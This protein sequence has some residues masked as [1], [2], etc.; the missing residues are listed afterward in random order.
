MYFFQEEDIVPIDSDFLRGIS[1]IVPEEIPI[2]S[3]ER[4]D[5]SEVSFHS[6]EV[7]FHSSEEFFIASVENDKYPS[8]DLHIIL[9]NRIIMY[10][11]MQRLEQESRFVR[12]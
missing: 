9:A 11:Q 7:S 1:Q 3:E 5:S 12:R 4:K 6:S 2:S 8:S 10:R